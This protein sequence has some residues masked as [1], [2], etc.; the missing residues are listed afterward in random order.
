MSNP[1]IRINYIDFHGSVADG[2]G[3]RSV[4]YLQGCIRRC[5]GCH[6][7]QTW[8]MLGGRLYDTNELAQLIVSRSPVRRITISGGEPLLQ[9]AAVEHLIFLLKKIHFD[10]ALYTGEELEDVPAELLDQLDYIKTGAFILSEK[11]TEVPYIGSTNQK[12]ICLRQ[13]REWD[14]EK[15]E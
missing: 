3:V 8:D 10:I 11:C 5:K 2:P 9:K 7:P 6:N 14:E 12:F 4:L 13:E 15:Y 1:D